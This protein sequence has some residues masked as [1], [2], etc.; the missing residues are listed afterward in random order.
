VPATEKDIAWLMFKLSF[1]YPAE[2]E[3]HIRRAAFKVLGNAWMNFKTK[4]VGE[5]IY[6]PANPDPKEKFP[7]IMEQV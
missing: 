6:N 7:W 5:F 3:D 1:D 4:L 2:H